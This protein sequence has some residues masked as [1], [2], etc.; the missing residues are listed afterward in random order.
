MTEMKRKALLIFCLAVIILGASWSLFWPG[1]FKIHDFIHGVRIAEMLRALQEGQIPVR[2][3]E[4]FGYG[5]GMPLFEFYAPLPYYVGAFLYGVGIPLVTS[6][7]VLFLLS[8]VGTAIGSYYLGKELFSHKSAGVL[9][10]AAYTLAPYRALNLFVRGALSEAWGMMAIPWILYGI[11]RIRK[12]TWQGFYATLFG[13]VILL[14]SHNLT[15]LIVAPFLVVFTL[16]MAGI[17]VLNKETTRNVLER[18]AVLF[19]GVMLAVGLSAFY[20][21]PAFLEKQFTQIESTILSGYFD[22][23]LH[24][25]YIRQ[26]FSSMWGYGGSEWGPEDPISFYLGTGQ[27]LGVITAA[28]VVGAGVVTL[29]KK[30]SVGTFLTTK[31]YILS[32][33][34]VL[35]TA[36]S[37]YMSLQRSIS[38]WR[39]IEPLSYIQFPW[40]YLSMASMGMAM[41]VGIPLLFMKGRSAR[42]YIVGMFC[43]LVASSVSYFRPETYLDDA[44][45]L[46]Y[47]NPR[48]VAEHMSDILPDYIP[49]GVELESITPPEKKVWCDDECGFDV[50]GETLVDRGHERLYKFNRPLRETAEMTFAIAD[51]PGWTVYADG[52]AVEHTQNDAGL[53]TAWIPLGTEF[54]GVQLTDTPVRS[55]SDA[56]SFA[57]VIVLLCVVIF[58]QRKSFFRKGVV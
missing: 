57:S 32:A 7:K 48:R 38:I 11:V 47:D 6:V 52:I 56:V 22:F 2:W 8:T 30:K 25:L 20:V 21:F 19:G 9:V 45:G 46:Y 27:W 40:R 12:N 17:D 3:T 14:L 55:A 44:S 4:H 26:F 39:A 33:L 16:G 5:Y 37:L 41:I 24:F 31:K 15:A 10:A 50:V 36:G 58:E 54:V 28:I 43:I 18:L 49:Q 34:L 51:Y 42:F 1:M 53:I 23:S 13:C 35:I 29:L